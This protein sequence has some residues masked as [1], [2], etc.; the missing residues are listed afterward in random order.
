MK[1]EVETLKAQLAKIEN[2]YT[3]KSDDITK[4]KKVLSELQNREMALNSQIVNETEYENCLRK[5]EEAEQELVNLNQAVDHLKTSNMATCRTID[6]LEN[7]LKD[8]NALVE[9]TDVKQLE[10]TVYVS[11]DTVAYSIRH[12]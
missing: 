5:I 9:H 1:K 7:I 3:S 6:A 12:L 10:E 11:R 8:I 4:F 2:E